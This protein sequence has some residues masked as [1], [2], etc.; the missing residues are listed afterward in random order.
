V[1]LTLQDD[2]NNIYLDSGFQENIQVSKDGGTTWKTIKAMVYR[3]GYNMT[4]S[5]GRTGEDAMSK[6]RQYQI[7]LD[8]STDA[9]LGLSSVSRAMNAYSFKL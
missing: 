7:A 3:D 2:F 5:G 4:T 6:A 1:N 9:T 8:I